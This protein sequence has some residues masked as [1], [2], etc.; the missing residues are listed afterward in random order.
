VDKG[1]S[2]AETAKKCKLPLDLT[3]HLCRL[4]LTHPGVDAEGIMIKIGK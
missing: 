1:K 4:Y 3:E 2:V